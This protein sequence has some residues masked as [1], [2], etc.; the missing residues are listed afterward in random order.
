MV[1]DVADL[2]CHLSGDLALNAQ[3]PLF[4]I[5]I[6]EVGAK[7]KLGCGPWISFG[8][9]REKRGFDVGTVDRGDIRQ[10]RETT[11]RIKD[12]RSVREWGALLHIGGEVVVSEV[13]GD[14][15]AATNHC[16]VAAEQT[17]EHA[18]SPG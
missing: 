14:A 4:R 15:E 18:R 13:V 6:A 10:T 1:S 3:V 12:G 7:L 8:R 11:I 2:R 16:F 5:R 9:Q 17:L